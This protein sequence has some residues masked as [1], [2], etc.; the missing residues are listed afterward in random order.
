M[1]NEIS[2]SLRSSSILNPTTT[3]GP[4]RKLPED[5]DELT[6]IQTR[7]V[8]SKRFKTS[9]AHRTVVGQCRLLFGYLMFPFQTETSTA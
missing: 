1:G 2:T 9:H 8:T 5:E 6:S 4:T 3:D 7:I